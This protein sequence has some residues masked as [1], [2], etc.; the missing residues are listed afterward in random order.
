MKFIP[1]TP[2]HL[3]P[4][5]LLLSHLK[6]IIVI[7]KWAHKPIGFSLLIVM[8]EQLDFEYYNVI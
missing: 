3:H 8:D 6:I 7:Y 2:S 1:I 4:L 5:H